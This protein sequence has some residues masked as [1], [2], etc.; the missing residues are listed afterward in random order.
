MNQKNR[1]FKAVDTLYILM[2]VLPVIAGLII[3]LLTKPASEGIT[4][5]GAQIFFEIPMP[6]QNLLIT[7]SQVNSLFVLIMVFG[8][9]L[10]L[11]HGIMGEKLMKRHLLAKWVVE[12]VEKMVV[13]NMGPYFKGFTSFVIAILALSGFSSLITLFGLFPPTSDVN[14]V[15]GW[16]VLVFILITYYKF[17]CGPVQYIK[18]LAD[19]VA[20][21]PLNLIG[22]VATPVSMAFRH[23]GNVLSGSVI[24]VLVATGLQGL[25]KLVLGFLPGFLGEF[26]FLQIGLPAVLSVYFDVFSGCLQAYIFAMLTMLYVSGGFPL[27]LYEERKRKKQQKRLMAKTNGGN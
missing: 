4:I 13:G 26:P 9:C 14:I 20:L 22:E 17:K 25:S 11:T 24:S 23:Y 3:K 2:M 19:P 27:E 18:G 15:A 5:T 10:Y 6:V 12:K 21:L 16:A 7:E 8:L 1:C